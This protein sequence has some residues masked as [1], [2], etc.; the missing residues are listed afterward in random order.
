MVSGVYSKDYLETVAD[1]I[2]TF[3]LLSG[4]DYICLALREVGQGSDVAHPSESN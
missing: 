1:V 4:L 2:N 3:R